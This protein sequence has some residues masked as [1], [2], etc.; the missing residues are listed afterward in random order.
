[1]SRRPRVELSVDQRGIRLRGAGEVVYDL[2]FDGR[3]VWSIDGGD[4]DWGDGGWSEVLWPAPLERQLSGAAHVELVEHVSGD[5]VASTD[6]V[7]GS[8]AHRVSVVGADGKPLA[9]TKWGRLVQP[10]SEASRES[11]EAYLNGVEEVLAALRD[12]CAVPAFL[13]FGSLLGAIRH[14]GVIPHDV[15]VDIGYLSAFDNPVDVMI[16]GFEIERRLNARGF[17]VRRQNGGFLAMQVRLPDGTSRNLDI[18]TAFVHGERLYQVNDIDVEADVSAVLPLG[19]IQFEGRPMPIPRQPTVFLESAYGP[20]W[21]TP[22]PAFS[23]TRPRRQRRRMRGWFGGLR[24]RRDALT[25]H[26]AAS[27]KGSGQPSQLAAW[28]AGR[29]DAG[30][31]VDLGCGTGHDAVYFVSRGFEVLAA[32]AALMPARRTFRSVP[33]QQRPRRLRINL[34]SVQEALTHGATVARSGKQHSLVAHSLHLMSDQAREN[35]WRFLRMSLDAGG[36]GY[37]EFRTQP[38]DTLPKELRS[39]VA[40]SLDPTAVQHEAGRFGLRVVERYEGPELPTPGAAD[41]HLC[42]MIVEARTKG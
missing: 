36:T 7:F 28:V 13:S 31:L 22:N 27:G 41:P 21:R 2:H 9:L 24:D 20:D 29:Q 35:A 40:G 4:L 10:F 11:I 23:F 14:G 18:F 37:V 42:W 38:D 25:R 17:K 1:M 30:P 34:D 5:T 16:E 8:D 15:D 39:V 19:S 6:V 12:D 33:R 26:Y 3:R 32:D